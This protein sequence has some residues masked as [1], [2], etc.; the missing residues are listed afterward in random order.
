MRNVVVYDVA[1]SERYIV[2][3]LDYYNQG[4]VDGE[5]NPE[6]AVNDHSPEPKILILD[7]T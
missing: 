7:K 2:I 1:A 6:M 3:L 4:G 5:Q